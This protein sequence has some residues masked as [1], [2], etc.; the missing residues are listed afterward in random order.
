MIKL[1]LILLLVVVSVTGEFG[2][3]ELDPNELGITAS[4][5]AKAHC[6]DKDALDL[7]LEFQG[8]CKKQTKF[9]YKTRR[10][11]DEVTVSK[12]IKTRVSREFAGI[13]SS[14]A[15]VCGVIAGYLCIRRYETGKDH[16]FQYQPIPSVENHETQQVNTEEEDGSTTHRRHHTVAFEDNL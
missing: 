15:C 8:P 1:V 4:E 6:S 10:T 13:M 9:Q 3:V 5:C 14:I 11:E 12:W 2:K 7:W 16:G